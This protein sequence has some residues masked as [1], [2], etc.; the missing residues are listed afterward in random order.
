MRNVKTEIQNTEEQPWIPA[1]AGMMDK[2]MRIGK[3]DLLFQTP[4]LEGEGSK[5]L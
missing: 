2:G 3:V 5:I 4:R 1:C